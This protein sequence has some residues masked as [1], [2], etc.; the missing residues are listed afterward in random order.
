LEVILEVPLCHPTWTSQN[1]TW[2]IKGIS[3]VPILLFQVVKPIPAWLKQHRNYG[4]SKSRKH[5]FD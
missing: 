4:L 1:Q 2:F 5:H 3:R